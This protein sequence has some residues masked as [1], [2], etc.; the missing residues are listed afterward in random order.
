MKIDSAKLARL[1]L[2]LWAVVGA[3][4][5]VVFGSP[6]VSDFRIDWSSFLLPGGACAVLVVAARFYAWR[7]DQRI[8]SALAATAM[9][10]VFSAV[11]GPLSYL[12]ASANFPLQDLFFDAADRALGFGWRGLFDWMNS[13][14]IAH[15]V[16]G[17]AYQSFTL[18]ASVAILCLSFTGRFVH[19]RTYL[20]AFMTAAVVTIV[21]S[22]VV[23][24][25]GVW[26]HYGLNAADHPAINPVTREFHLPI[27]H[28][29]RDGSYRLLAGL[30]SMGI[31]TFPSFHSAIALLFIFAF[32]PVPVMRWIG[33]VVNVLMIV[34]TPVDGGHYFIDVIAG[35]VIAVGCWVAAR[36]L[37]DRLLAF[38]LNPQIVAVQGTTLARD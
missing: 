30:G 7:Q 11:G 19:L 32:W 29:L 25:Q 38:R 18:Q 2:M 9:L 37:V 34:A 31:I 10:L 14:P 1:D 33:L 3:V 26:G 8:A 12:A 20:L 28:G 4:A 13:S 21:I 5:A 27:F 23:P 22:A 15:P 35:V 17:F 6:L 16:F 36:A 24:A